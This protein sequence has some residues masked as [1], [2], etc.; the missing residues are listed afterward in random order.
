[1]SL[2]MLRPKSPS[3]YYLKVLLSFWCALARGNRQGLADLSMRMG[4]VLGLWVSQ[5]QP[6]LSQGI[7][8]IPWQRT[9]LE[10]FLENIQK[11]KQHATTGI[12]FRTPFRAVYVMNQ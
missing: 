9:T 8:I 3:P 6:P 1:M 10:F 11:E 5:C 12:Y 2:F 7:G 4:L